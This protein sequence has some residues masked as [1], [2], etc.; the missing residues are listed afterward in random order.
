M[1]AV[2]AD[3]QQTKVVISMWSATRLLKALALDRNT[4]RLQSQQAVQ[5][6]R[7]FTVQPAIDHFSSVYVHTYHQHI[8]RNLSWHKWLVCLQRLKGLLSS[9]TREAMAQLSSSVPELLIM[10]PHSTFLARSSMMRDLMGVG[11][12]EHEAAA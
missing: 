11:W 3:D 4:G 9:H 8:L 12:Q 10:R 5:V 6:L 7:C 1:C 2:H